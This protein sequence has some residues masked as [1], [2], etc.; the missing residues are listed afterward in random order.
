MVG[1]VEEVEEVEMEDV[2]V[3]AEEEEVDMIG[4]SISDR[5]LIQ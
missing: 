2:L 5:H 1:A 4:R 3:V